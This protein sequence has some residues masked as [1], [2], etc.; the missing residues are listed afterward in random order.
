MTDPTFTI[1]F[2]PHKKH[3]L[4]QFIDGQEID[5]G[6]FD[7][8]ALALDGIHIILNPPPL[9]HFGKDGEPLHDVPTTPT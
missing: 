3:R 6:L 8:H 5:R 7:T 1:Q 4:K 9:A 2:T